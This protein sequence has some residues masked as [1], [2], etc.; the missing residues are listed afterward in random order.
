M[1]TI[2][3]T[4]LALF[5]IAGFAQKKEILEMQRDIALL[6]DQVRTMQRSQDEKFAQVTLLLQQALDASGKANTAMAVLQSSLTE[7]IGEQ[8]KSMVGPVAGVGTKVDQMADEFRSGDA[9]AMILLQRVPNPS[10]YG[11]AELEDG[12]VVR[13]QEKPPQPR[14]RHSRASRNDWSKAIRK[15]PIAIRLPP[16]IQREKKVR[17]KRVRSS[18]GFSAKAK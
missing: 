17:K 9:D 6:Q 12:R 14:T 10:A 2:A 11:V 3:V 8:A 7:R 16:I 1:K 13:L 5:P 18:L 4:L 15:C